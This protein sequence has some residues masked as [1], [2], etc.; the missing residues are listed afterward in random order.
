[1]I[2]EKYEDISKKIEKAKTA[3]EMYCLAQEEAIGIF[4][5][6]KASIKTIEK[7]KKIQKKADEIKEASVSD[8]ILSSI[9][10]GFAGENQ[11]DLNKEKIGLI[12]EAIGLTNESLSH[13]N[14]LIQESIKFTCQSV[15]FA[16]AMSTIISK[17]IED[18]FRDRDG[19]MI[20][21]TKIQREI[22]HSIKN[23]AEQHIRENQKYEIWKE[24]CFGEIASLRARLEKSNTDILKI[25]KI[26]VFAIFLSLSTLVLIVVLFLTKNFL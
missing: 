7:A 22:F 18:G 24:E 25:K 8:K 20:S 12:S 16:T 2:L 17:M 5:K 23:G 11:S 3:E 26:G 10:F 21:L 1:M 15:A 4:E 9:T 19:N 14:M 6:I 13:M